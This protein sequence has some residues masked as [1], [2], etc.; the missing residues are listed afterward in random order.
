M[1]RA[2]LKLFSGR[3]ESWSSLLYSSNR[4]LPAK[5]YARRMNVSNLILRPKP[6]DEPSRKPSCVITRLRVKSS[7]GPAK[8]SLHYSSTLNVDKHFA[9]RIHFNHLTPIAKEKR[10]VESSPT[11][12]SFWHILWYQAFQLVDH[13]PSGGANAC[14]TSSGWIL[15][16]LCREAAESASTGSTP[17]D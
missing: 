1:R 11:L 10:H 13:G 14:S 2:L 7:V 6:L 9:L 15:T 5:G 4:C 16:D 3:Y 17:Q 8:F 12:T